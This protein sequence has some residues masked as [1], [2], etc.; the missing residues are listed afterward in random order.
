MAT[1]KTLEGSDSK[2]EVSALVK[3][4]KFS[5]SLLSKAEEFRSTGKIQGIHRIAKQIKAERT[6]LNK[7]LSNCESIITHLYMYMQSV[8]D[9]LDKAL[10]CVS[11]CI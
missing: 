3:R 6:M 1:A 4:L 9:L 11:T 8:A 5:E 10:V 2:S 7:V